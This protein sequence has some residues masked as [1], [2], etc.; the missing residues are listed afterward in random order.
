M[1]VD[2][3]TTPGAAP[4]PTLEPSST[5]R[6]FIGATVTVELAGGTAI[7]SFSFHATDEELAELKPR[8]AATRWPELETVNDYTQDL[9]L[10]TIQKLSNHLLNHDWR[11]V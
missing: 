6:P 3:T 7:R 9:R 5:E 10:D 2:T 1:S 11:K 8:I 4:T